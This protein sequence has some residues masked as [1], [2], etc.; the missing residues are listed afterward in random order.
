MR[1]VCWDV[2]PLDLVS[3]EVLADEAVV[4]FLCQE[5]VEVVELVSGPNKVEA[6][7]ALDGPG[8]VSPRHESVET[9]SE[10]RIGEV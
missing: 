7:I 10:G 8:A 3:E 5:L 4:V 1:G 2:Q 9:G 6:I